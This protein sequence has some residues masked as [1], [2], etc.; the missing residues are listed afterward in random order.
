MIMTPE[1]FEEYLENVPE[2]IG[3]NEAKELWADIK[4][5]KEKRNWAFYHHYTKEP[6][7]FKYENSL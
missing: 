4:S 1:E 6:I 2:G 7:F 3:R 5:G